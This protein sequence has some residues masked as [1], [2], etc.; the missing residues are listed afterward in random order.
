MCM[1]VPMRV[2]QINGDFG[3]VELG[4]VRREVSLQLVE[5][6]R[7]NDYVIVHAGF[8]IE[9]LDEEAARETLELFRQMEEVMGHEI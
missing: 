2:I 5:D 3:V 4:G 9:K 6:V 7:E 8:A 1:A